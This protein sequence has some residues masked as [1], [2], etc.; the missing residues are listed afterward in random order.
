MPAPGTRTVANAWG[1]LAMEKFS[2]KYE[3]E[4]VSGTTSAGLDDEARGGL[5]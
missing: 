1:V 3:S 2:R 5:G 4:N